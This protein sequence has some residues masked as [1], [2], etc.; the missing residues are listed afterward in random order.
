MYTMSTPSGTL[1]KDGVVIESDDSKPA[2][3]E[4]VQWL[5]AGHGPTE[6]ADQAPEPTRQH[7]TVTAW[8]LRK[9]LISM[10]MHEQVKQAVAASGDDMVMTGW[11][12][13]TEFESDH[14]MLLNMLPLL[15]MDED[16]MYSLF[17]LA[18]SL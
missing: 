9:A 15:G 13:A 2:Y 8:Q 14:P 7:I 10:G 1:R 18:K 5:T 12:Y 6:I 4:Y 16:Q 17:E 3:R 11:E